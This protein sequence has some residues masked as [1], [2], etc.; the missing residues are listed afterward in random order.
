MKKL[1]FTILIVMTFI[2]CGDKDDK[3]PKD[4]NKMIFQWGTSNDDW[5]QSAILDDLNNIIVAGTQNNSIFVYKINDKKI[6]YTK[7]FNLENNKSLNNITLKFLNNNIYLFANMRLEVSGGEVPVYK[8]YLFVMKLDNQGNEIY[9]KELLESGMENQTFVDATNTNDDFYILSHK[10]TDNNS[11]DIFIY[12][13]N[14]NGIVTPYIDFGTDKDDKAVS[15][16]YDKK[17]ESIYVAGTTIGG[18]FKPSDISLGGSDVFVAEIKDGNMTWGTILGSSKDDYVS[19]IKSDS[20]GNIYVLG[21]TDGKILNTI[22]GEQ[23]IFISNLNVQGTVVLQKQLGTN[24]YDFSS[25][26]V[27]DD[28]IY[29]SGYTN[30]AVE[31]S[32]GKKDVYFAK[33]DK[34]FNIISQKQWGSSEDEEVFSLLKNN[35]TL[36]IVGNTDGKISKVS[37]KKDLFI[38]TKTTLEKQ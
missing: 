21:N 2:S 10:R 9:K 8:N 20:L 19:D 18:K 24:S 3:K 15:I 27:V 17:R 23:D 36:Y 13:L 4:N 34:D 5:G 29:I 28:N 33:L 32:F 11:I 30:G 26:L 38:I 6:I 1:I 12:K 7:N 31:K 25:K 35:E 37:G 16:F 22:I 14:E